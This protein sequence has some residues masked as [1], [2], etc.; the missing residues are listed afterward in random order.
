MIKASN[1][2]V[3]TTSKDPCLRVYYDIIQC[4]I[5]TQNGKIGI[6]LETK[7]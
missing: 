2:L 4:Q 3:Y 7:A 1:K 5:T 6:F